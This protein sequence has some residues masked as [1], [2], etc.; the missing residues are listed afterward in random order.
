MQIRAR[1]HEWTLWVRVAVVPDRRSGTRSEV[2]WWSLVSVT[3]QLQYLPLEHSL[4][5]AKDYN[6]RK[7]TC[8][9]MISASP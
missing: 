7:S 9:S 6:S 1:K 4:S 5:D 8:L 2:V 3:P